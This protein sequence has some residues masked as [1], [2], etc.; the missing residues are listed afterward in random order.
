MWCLYS[1]NEKILFQEQYLPS[2]SICRTFSSPTLY[3]SGIITVIVAAKIIKVK[4]KVCGVFILLTK[5]FISGTIL[6][7]LFN[8]Q[9]FF[10]L[11]LYMLV[12]SIVNV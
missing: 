12:G 2:H 5:G 11:L 9:D 8:L 10:P 7:Y 4:R 3:V 1:T 6:A